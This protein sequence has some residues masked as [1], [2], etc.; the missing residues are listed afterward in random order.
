MKKSKN[1]QQILSFLF[2]LLTLGV[3]L[4]IGLNGN[5]LSELMSALKRLSPGYLLLCFASWVLYVL[6]DA[7]AIHHFLI[8]QKTPVRL[9]Q[10]IHAAIVGIYYCNITPGASGGQPMQM[11]CLSKYKV[12]IGV[13][14][15]AVAVKFVVFQAVLLLTGAVLWPLHGRFVAEYAGSSIWFVLLGY[16]VNFFSI[17]MVLM[18]AISTRAVRWVIERCICIGMRLKICKDPDA[19][20]TKWENHCQSFLSSVQQVVRRP[21]DLVIQCLIAFIQLMSLMLVIIAVYHAFGLSGVGTTELITMG[22]LLYIAASYT[23]LPGA[24]GAQEGGFAVMFRDIFPEA[25]CFVAL[26]IWR[27]AT[28]YLSVLVGAVVTSVENIRS[29]RKSSAEEEVNPEN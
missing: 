26:L 27:F 19:S 5:D 28:Y 6:A 13:S 14:G 24:S 8:V 18:M 15:S 3:V 29:L 4:W 25:H 7:L 10:S 17:G 2:L 1:L 16:V 12:P 11:Y 22:V 23:P 20:R 9:W 21:A